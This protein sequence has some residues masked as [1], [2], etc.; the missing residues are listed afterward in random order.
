MGSR[1]IVFVGIYALIYPH[2]IL[3]EGIISRDGLPRGVLP[4]G[5]LNIE[6]YCLGL[7]FFRFPK[8]ILAKKF[9][10]DVFVSMPCVKQLKNFG[11]EF[12]I[13]AT[14]TL[15]TILKMVL[16]VFFSAFA[17]GTKNVTNIE[18]A[19]QTIKNCHQ[20]KVNDIHFSLTCM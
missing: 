5:I 8:Y 14:S 19:S 10:L 16:V 7:N 4:S 17:S 9:C 18:I 6:K 12:V 20:H 13:R 2:T 1:S 11:Y 3:G 15:E